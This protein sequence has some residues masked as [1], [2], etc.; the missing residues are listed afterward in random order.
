MAPG[1]RARALVTGLLA[2]TFGGMFGV[3]GGIILIPLLTAWLGA[4]QHRAHGTSLAVTGITALAS[5]AIYAVNH[6]VEWRTAALVGIGS[7]LTARYGARFASRV[8]APN[9]KRAFAVFLLLVGM[10]LLWDPA[11]AAVA[12]V[13]GPA[14][15][16]VDVALGAAIGLLAGF[17]GVG[18]GILAVPGFA[19]LFGMPQQLAQGT[20][21]AVILVTAPVG[22]IENL[23]LGNVLV[24]LLAMLA[25]GAAVGAVFASLVV[26]R[27]PSEALTR[28]FAVFQVLTAGLTWWSASRMKPVPATP[29]TAPGRSP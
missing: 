1:E 13:S 16:A 10:R 14:A 25:I 28:G 23:R 8:S 29:G 2:G 9:L 6:N 17:M 19:L 4:T 22:T 24:R 3:G 18:G 12:V 7:A 15:I 20:S 5:L 26:Q 21:L 11:P 27:M